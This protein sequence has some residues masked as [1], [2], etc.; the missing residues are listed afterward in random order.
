MIFDEGH[1]IVSSILDIYSPKITIEMINHSIQQLQSYYDRYKDRLASQSHSYI[2]HL[3]FILKQ[4]VS[5][6]TVSRVSTVS[7]VST[8]TS[9]P[10]PTPTSTPASTP[11]PAP[12][13]TQVFSTDRFLQVLQLGG[14]NLFDIVHFIQSKRIMYKLNLFVDSSNPQQNETSASYFQ[15]ILSFITLLTSK[16]EDS[17]IIVHIDTSSSSYLQFLFLNPATYFNDIL[18]ECRSVLIAGG[19]LQPVLL[20]LPSYV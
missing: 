4:F 3:L 2:I 8:P 17:R 14:I 19:T 10:T 7:T 6:L 16:K 18:N 15:H 9:T 12:P 1:N 11:T 20:F 5:I 13:S